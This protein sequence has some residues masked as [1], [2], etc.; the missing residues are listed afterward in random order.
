LFAETQVAGLEVGK[1]YEFYW[2][3]SEGGCADF[4]RDTVSVILNER[5]NQQA[6]VDAEMQYICD[7]EDIVL[8]AEE[9]IF[10]SGYWSTSSGARIANP[11]SPITRADRLGSGANVFVWTLSNENCQN[12]SSDSLVAFVDEGPQVEDELIQINF[13]EVP[14]GFDVASNDVLSFEDY[15]ITIDTTDLE[16]SLSWDADRRYTFKPNEAFVGETSFTYTYCHKTCED[17]CATGVATFRIEPSG[18]CIIPSIITPNGDG[19]NDAFIIP[20]VEAYPESYFCVFNRW[21]DEVYVSENYKN[22][23]EGTYKGGKLPAGTYF[24][25]VKINDGDNMPKKG[26]VLIQY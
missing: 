7:E 12:Y 26:Y 22:D 1:E 4:D 6:F 5:P 17:K 25:V 18:G 16:G 3:L 9:P 10:G 2:S 15:T 14:S 21:G 19:M 20:C 24:Y 13:G 8:A 11:S 23:W